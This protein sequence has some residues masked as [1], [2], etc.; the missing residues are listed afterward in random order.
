MKTRGSREQS[1]QPEKAQ[2]EASFS[3]GIGPLSLGAARLTAPHRPVR[4][5]MATA[6]PRANGVRHPTRPRAFAHSSFPSSAAAPQN[7]RV[8]GTNFTHGKDLHCLAC[9]PFLMLGSLPD[10]VYST[11]APLRQHRARAL[12]AHPPSQRL[13]SKR[14]PVNP[15]MPH[16]DIRRREPVVVEQSTGSFAP[17]KQW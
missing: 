8:S 7:C 15:P 9:L 10:R 16:S 12:H 6:K 2:S 1:L 14:C 3:L 11:P 17:P 5:R 13:T 4:S